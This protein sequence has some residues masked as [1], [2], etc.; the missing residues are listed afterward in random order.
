MVVNQKCDWCQFHWLRGYL[1]V[2]IKIAKI[3][4]QCNLGCTRLKVG[5]FLYK[6]V[7]LHLPCHRGFFFLFFA[8]SLFALRIE[9]TKDILFLS[10]QRQIAT[11]NH[12]YF[13]SL[14]LSLGH[15]TSSLHT[16]HLSH[17]HLVS[18]SLSCAHTTSVTRCLKCLLNIWPFTTT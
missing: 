9:M 10:L 13:L 1:V 11:F 8:L 15:T 14:S 2:A 3:F 6:N 4:C 17:S 5:H 18:L 16:L 7:I 12:K